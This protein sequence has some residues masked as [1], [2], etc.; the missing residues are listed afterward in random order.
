M[1]NIK[2][3]NYVKAVLREDIPALSN[4]DFPRKRMANK[5]SLGSQ[6]SARGAAKTTAAATAAAKTKAVRS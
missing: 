3:P 6:R 4:R 2:C 1:D 5:K